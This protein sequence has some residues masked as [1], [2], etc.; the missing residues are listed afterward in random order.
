MHACN[1]LQFYLV[2]IRLQ[3]SC[4][5]SLQCQCKYKPNI[6]YCNYLTSKAL[7]CRNTMWL[8]LWNSH[9]KHDAY[10][11]FKNYIYIYQ[12]LN[13]HLGVNYEFTENIFSVTFQSPCI[14]MCWL[15]KCFPVVIYAIHTGTMDPFNRADWYWERLAC[16]LVR[17]Q[18]G[19]IFSVSQGSHVIWL[20]WRHDSGENPPPL[21]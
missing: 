5:L 18:V 19:M 20:P 14:T 10:V 17:C 16:R 12:N 3:V 11:L 7:N 2:D 13:V 21:C 9:M 8:S 6:S 1:A 15:C 4:S